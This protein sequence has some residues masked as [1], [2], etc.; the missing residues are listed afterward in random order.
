MYERS[1][2]YQNP[3]KR[4]FGKAEKATPYVMFGEPW[5]V[6][7]LGPLG[8]RF[9]TSSTSWTLLNG[10]RSPFLGSWWRELIWTFTNHFF[11]VHRVLTRRI[12]LEI[13]MLS[14]ISKKAGRE[15]GE[16]E[17]QTKWKGKFE[18]AQNR[19]QSSSAHESDCVSTGV[20]IGGG[21]KPKT[22]N[23]VFCACPNFSPV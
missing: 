16:S 20:E 6:L 3:L 22:W 11:I 13:R 21:I 8:Q 7:V 2:K 1:E 14:N 4:S 9:M 18:G 5:F 12:R 19:P 23:F 10:V 17:E 15:K